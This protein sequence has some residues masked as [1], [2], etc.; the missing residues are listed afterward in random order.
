MSADKKKHN[1]ADNFKP[2]GNSRERFIAS[3]SSTKVAFWSEFEK[4]GNKAEKWLNRA[5]M[6]IGGTGGLATG[7]GLGLLT[8]SKFEEKF[9][10]KEDQ[11]LKDKLISKGPLLGGLAGGIAG[12]VHGKS[13]A[14]LLSKFAALKKDVQL[15]EH[16]SRAVQRLVENDGSL[17]IAHATGS[18]KTLTGIAG[19]EELKSIGKAK[20]AIV[21]VPAALRENFV[22]NLKNFTQ[23]SSHAVY[24]PKGES[25]SHDVGHVSTAD[26]NIISYDLFREHGDQIL[27]DT[28]ADTLIMDEIHKV[29]GTEGSTYNK[30]RDLRPNFKNAITLTGSVV[31]NEPNEVVPLLDITYGPT[32]HKLV[33]KQFFDKLFVK[34]DAK[35]VG[36]ISPKVVIEKNL[37]NKKALKHYLESKID[38]VGHEAIEKD[39]PKKNVETVEVNMSPEQKRVYDF[40]MASVDPVTRWKIRNNIPV[41]Q[42]E[43]QEA[44]GKLMQARQISTDPAVMDKRFE[45]QHPHE[46]SP[47]VTAVLKDLHEHLGEAE[48]HK[49]VIFGNLIHGQVSTI[50]KTLLHHKIPFSKFVGMGQEGSS[51][52]QRAQSIQ[53]F[54]GGKSRVLLISGAGAEGLDLKN[55]TMMQ[56]LEGHYNPERIHQAESRVRRLGSKVPE[57]KIRRYVAKP[58]PHGVIGKA[59]SAVSGGGNQGVDQWIYTIAERKNRLNSDFRDVLNKQASVISEKIANFGR[60]LDEAGDLAGSE[61]AG[62]FFENPAN[63]LIQSYGSAFGKAIGGIPGEIVKRQMIKSTDKD[64]EAKLK[65]MLLDKGYESLTQKIHY[66]KIMAESKQDE[67]VIDAKAGLG[68]LSVGL[69]ILATL[70]P[71][72]GNKMNAGISKALKAVLSEKTVGK[73]FSH[74][75]L[76]IAAPSMV[77][78]A[79]IGMGLPIAQEY[80]RKVILTGALGGSKDLDTGINLYIEKLRK[81]NERKY[82]SSKGFVNE[83][84]TKKDLGIDTI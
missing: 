74:P 75:L 26:Y 15:K 69:P 80:A 36:L 35:K 19:F 43:A 40:T 3:R 73:I 13:R 62:G 77:G 68:A 55:A 47:K 83:Y 23:G 65:Q 20:R 45:S 17:L 82:K 63:A 48:H 49:S 2:K 54:T 52:K 5:G 60:F 37:T 10:K 70:H 21:V 32:G 56:M 46:Y 79:L 41:G 53:D 81:K 57:V 22:E 16:Q 14:K 71:Q 84:E 9:K 18:G 72:I 50:E 30:L 28:G 64:V 6:F 44:F 66:P 42:R 76:R 61:S 58:A 29:R 31:N 59:M 25:K 12:A 4:Q 27:K 78:G 7:A 1:P 38:Y 67:R 33:S 39:L 34:K 24:G 11:T 8:R 51:A